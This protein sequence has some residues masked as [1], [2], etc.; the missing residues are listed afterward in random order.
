MKSVGFLRE[1][2]RLMLAPVVVG[3]VALALY[4]LGMVPAYWQSSVSLREFSSLEEAE[5]VLGFEVVVPAYFP[6]YLSWPPAEI[7]GQ[8]EPIPMAQMLFLAADRHT[9]AL[10]I[11]QILSDREGLPSAVPWIETIQQKITV[12]INGNSGQLIIGKGADGQSLNSVHWRADG[13]HF[14]VVTIHPVKE[15]LTLARSMHP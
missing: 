4:L 8:L 6:S 1:A 2:P 9:K 14:I 5:S 3:V 15:L 11:S 7:R 10:L 13:L 12:D